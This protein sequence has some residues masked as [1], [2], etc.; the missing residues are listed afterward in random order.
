MIGSYVARLQA[1][2][3]IDRPQ[4]PVI[5]ERD[6]VTSAYRALLPERARDAFDRQLALARTV[7]PHIEDHNFYID[8]WSHTVLWNKAREFGALLSHHAFLADAED[9]FFLRPDEVRA[10]LEELRMHWSSG[11]QGVPR[12]PAHWPPKVERRKTIHQALRRWAPPPALG[13]APKAVTEP[14]TIMH[15][16]ITTERVHGWLD[17]SGGSTSRMRGIAA[18]PGVAEGVARVILD[19][20]QVSDTQD[21][22][23]LVAPFTSTSWTPVFGRIA[24]VVTDAGGVMCHAAIVA[25]EYRVPAVLGAGTATKHITTG[26]LIRVDGDNGVITILDRPPP[27]LEP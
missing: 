3:D 24:G 18:S 1:G 6:R 15:W 7:F 11:G 27:P 14:V 12:G 26:D 19:V 21:G 8:H 22:E 13:P 9:V 5:A 25:R 17:A 16:G 10:A 4:N 20:G 23:I 2:E